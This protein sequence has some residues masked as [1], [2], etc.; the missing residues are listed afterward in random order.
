MNWVDGHQMSSK[1]STS[2]LHRREILP[3][4]QAGLHMARFRSTLVCSSTERH[5]RDSRRTRRRLAPAS[6][7]FDKVKLHCKDAVAVQACCA[8]DAFRSATTS[9]DQA[10]DFGILRWSHLIS[11]RPPFYAPNQY[12][13]PPSFPLPSTCATLMRKFESTYALRMVM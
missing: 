1:A 3:A 8:C 5:N 4:R 6:T 10:A 7:N 13:R 2:G 9:T 12:R 11:V